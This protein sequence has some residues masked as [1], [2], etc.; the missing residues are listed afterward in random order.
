MG[1]LMKAALQIFT[2][3]RIQL[4]SASVVVGFSEAVAIVAYQIIKHLKTK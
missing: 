4:W 1:K 3:M 2:P